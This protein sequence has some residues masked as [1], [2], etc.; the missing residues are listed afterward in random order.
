MSNFAIIPDS[1][2]DMT[3]D[4]RERFGIED[5]LHG[6][7]YKQDGSQL[8]ANLDWDELD[9]DIGGPQEYY[10]SMKG[11][12]KLYTTA[13]PPLGHVYDVFEK[14]LRAGRDVLSISLSGG[15]SGSYSNTVKVAEDLQKKYPER[16]IFCIDSKRYSTALTLLVIE[17]CKKRK[18]GL[19]AEQTAAHLLS[20]RDTVH[21]MGSMNDLF[22]LVKTGRITNFKALFGSMI[23]LNIMADFSHTGMSQVCGKIKGQKD[24]IEATIAYMKETIEKPEEQIIF[25]AHTSRPV[26]AQLLKQR[27]EETFHPAE[28]ILTTVGPSCGASVGPGLCA[29]FYQGKPI[30]QDFS[31]ETALMETCIANLAKKPKRSK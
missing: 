6:I 25:V 27:I 4:L 5:Y 8:S 13:T 7:L 24:A 16:K 17:A 9:W 19:T 31:K 12:T 14:Y 29:A 22:F 26:A 18:E 30:S 23:G 3:R 11:H 10:D 15:L 2:C 21:Q 28:L 1:S 20:M